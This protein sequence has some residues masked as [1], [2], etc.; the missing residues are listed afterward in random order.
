MPVTPELEF[1]CHLDAELGQPIPIGDT[2]HGHRIIVPILG[3]RLEGPRIKAKILSGGNDWLL[4]RPDGITELDV[5]VTLET[6]DGALIYSAYRGLATNVPAVMPRWAQGE[7]ISPD[8]YS[9]TAT[10][11]FETS[12]PQ[13]AWLQQSVMIGVVRLVR[14]GVA[15]D[16]F[17]VK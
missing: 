11:A 6:D 14:G 17:A 7:E 3:G 15:Y 10:P 9:I 16:V 13:Y 12:A 1:I 4:I 2:P 8:E 5:R